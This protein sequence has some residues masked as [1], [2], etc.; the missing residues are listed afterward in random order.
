MC[1]SVYVCV[2]VY[3]HTHTYT[4]T[5]IYM[6]IYVYTQHMCVLRGNALDVSLLQLNQID[7]SK[8][9]LSFTAMGIKVRVPFSN[10][11]FLKCTAQRSQRWY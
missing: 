3:I 4:D 1:V 9:L 10:S 7:K 8:T 11:D 2:C 5:H 6:C